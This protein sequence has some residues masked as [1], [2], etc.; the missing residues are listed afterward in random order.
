[1]HEPMPHAETSYFPHK[2]R[3]IFSICQQNYPLQ[4]SRTSYTSCIS[5]LS[6]RT[7]HFQL[8]ILE[9]DTLLTTHVCMPVH[10]PAKQ[11]VVLNLLNPYPTAFPYGNGM[12]LHFYQ[13]QE[14]STT[15]TVHKVINKGLKTYV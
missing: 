12:V 3:A 5:L 9:K 2:K 7:D 8:L 13:Q 11:P 15:K 10:F 6:L 14:S 4:G 1:M